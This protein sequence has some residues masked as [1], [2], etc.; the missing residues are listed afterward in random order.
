MPD[1]FATIQQQVKIRCRV[2]Q[3]L[4][5]GPTL[6]Q[7]AAG[8]FIGA[9]AS[10]ADGTQVGPTPIVEEAYQVPLTELLAD[11]ELGAL[12]QTALGALEQIGAEMCKRHKQDL[13][14]RMQIIEQIAGEP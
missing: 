13:L 10:N 9:Y 2:I 8:F 7:K 14:N 5:N 3:A 4:N 12:A 11:P 6:D 1:I